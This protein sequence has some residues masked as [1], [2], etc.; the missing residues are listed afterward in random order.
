[1][2]VH[3]DFLLASPGAVVV[4]LG[5][6]SVTGAFWG[7]V[8]TSLLRISLGFVGAAVVGTLV[9]ALAARFRIAEELARPLIGAIR[10]APVVSFI[11]L[12]LLW[13][14][15]S[16]LS[17]IVS[18]LMVLP[19][20][21]ANILEGIRNRDRQL[22]EAAAVFRVPLLRRIRAI[23]VPAVLPFFSAACRVGVGLAWKSGVAAE[24]I[25]IA[26]GTIGGQLYQ[27][28]LF[29]DSASLFAWT[30]VIIALSAACEALVLWLLRRA[31]ARL[32]GGVS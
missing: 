2:V 29:L 19:V 3:R 18:F 22:L 4:R 21:Y 26:R 7:T 10:S 31:Q 30:V 17:A 11:I 1:M 14:D 12:L 13:T 15:S 24:V 16:R 27:S 8:G 20:M 5:K 28:K 6:L 25:G 23:D 32:A 9:A